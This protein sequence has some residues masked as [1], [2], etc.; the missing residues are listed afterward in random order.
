MGT[1]VVFKNV[2]AYYF[3]IHI[4]LYTV[5]MPKLRHNVEKNAVSPRF[6]VVYKNKR[7][8]ETQMAATVLYIP[9]AVSLKR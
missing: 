1:V 7:K 4:L 5:A 3:Y 9:L 6:S 2:Q 8:W